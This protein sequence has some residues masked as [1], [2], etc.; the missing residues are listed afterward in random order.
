V[1]DVL[2]WCWGVEVAE[3]YHESRSDG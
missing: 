1:I 2:R 3:V